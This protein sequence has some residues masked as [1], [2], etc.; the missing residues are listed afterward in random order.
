MI[1]PI[2]ERAGLRVIQHT[3]KAPGGDSPYS[4]FFE[5]AD[6]QRPGATYEVWVELEYASDGKR[7]RIDCI[8]VVAG[9]RERASSNK[10]PY[11][12]VGQVTD[13]AAHFICKIVRTDERLQTFLRTH[14]ATSRLLVNAAEDASEGAINKLEEVTIEINA[15]LERH[16]LYLGVNRD[17]NLIVL[18]DKEVPRW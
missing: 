3:Y 18:S 1:D 5:F 15:V 7:M 2:F 10:T 4:F 17:N 8:A 13:E 16:G 9:C 6:E 12:W 14:C 11:P